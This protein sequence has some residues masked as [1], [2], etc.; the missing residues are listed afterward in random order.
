MNITKD[1]NINNTVS[2]NGLR[3]PIYNSLPNTSGK[4]GNFLIQQIIK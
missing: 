3:I 2:L 1:K 4:L